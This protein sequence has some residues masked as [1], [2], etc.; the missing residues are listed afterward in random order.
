MPRTAKVVAFSTTPEMAEEIDRLA[1]EEGRTRSELLR[2]AVRAYRLNRRTPPDVV[3]EP[4]AHYG[5]V[6]PTAPSLPGLARI[7]GVRAELAKLCAEA[8]VARLWAFGSAV[9]DDFDP[10][11]SDFDLLV[12]FLAATPR[13]PWL[14]ELFELRDALSQL[15]GGPVDLGEAGALKNP[16]VNA[17][18]EAE[19]VLVFEQ[20]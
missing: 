19:K 2:E 15:L 6:A 18:V 9:R 3:A 17:A 14:G 1:A 13:Q 10:R 8:G 16:Y 7:L 20:S 5:Q 12:E 11:S 4:G